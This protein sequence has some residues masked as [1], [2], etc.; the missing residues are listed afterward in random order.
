[1]EIKHEYKTISDSDYDRQEGVREKYW[2]K[3][4]WIC[5]TI[6]KMAEEGWELYKRLSGECM[7]FRR[8]LAP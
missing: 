7:V 1:M 6:E 2:D 3:N 4:E 8:K 5:K